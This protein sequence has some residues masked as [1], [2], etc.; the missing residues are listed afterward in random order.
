MRGGSSA[1]IATVMMKEA[2]NVSLA[3]G[4]RVRA[5][6]V[7]LGLSQEEL[8]FRAGVDRTYMSKIERGIGNPTI[9]TLMRVSETLGVDV[10]AL[11]GN[12]A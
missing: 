10:K 5:L 2:D 7:A 3:I 11:L 4:G 9:R 6:R 1:C 8:A 12:E